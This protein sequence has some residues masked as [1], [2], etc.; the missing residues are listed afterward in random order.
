MFQVQLLRKGWLM[1]TSPWG[2]NWSEKCM[3][4]SRL[5]APPAPLT[6]STYHS[7]L[8]ECLTPVLLLDLQISQADELEPSIACA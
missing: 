1:K 4:Q 6:I 8:Q 7:L 3:E 5:H 2:G